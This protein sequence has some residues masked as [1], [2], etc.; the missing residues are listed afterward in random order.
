MIELHPDEKIVLERRRF[1]LPILTEAVLTG[2]VAIAPL[3]LFNILPN[4]LPEAAELIVVRFQIPL[5]F[6]ATIWALFA[7]MVLAVNWT[8][9]YLDVLLVTNKRVLDI[10][11]TGLFARDI[12]EARI[13]NIQDTRVEVVGLL[14]S[15]F[16]FG[17]LYIQ[18][19]AAKDQ[20]VIRNIRHPNAV[21]DAIARQHEELQKGGIS[22]SP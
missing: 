6:L 12:A 3:V 22:S 11:Q 21:K 16:D 19:A 15:L 8:N 20:F 5:N 10:E 1:W 18:T 13:E 4:V 7:W 14:A 17:N 9:F 2:L